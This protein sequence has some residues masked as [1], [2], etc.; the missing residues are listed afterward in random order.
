VEA[1]QHAKET[2]LMREGSSALRSPRRLVVNKV[3]VAAVSLY[4]GSAAQRRHHDCTG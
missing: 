4:A 1:G 2:L 3:A